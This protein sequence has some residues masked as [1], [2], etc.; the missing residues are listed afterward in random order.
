MV[1][2][3]LIGCRKD[4]A[5]YAEAAGRLRGA[6]FVATVDADPG[7]AERAATAFGTATAYPELEDLIAEDL[8]GFDAMV[9]DAPSRAHGSLVTAA[10]MLR[11]HVL[12]ESPLALSTLDA[13]EATSACQTAG[14]RLMV[15][16]AARFVPTTQV[17]K[18]SIDSGKLGQ[19]G[20]LRIHRWESRDTGDWHTLEAEA[21]IDGG[22]VMGQV[23]RE[24]DLARWM[25]G[26][27][28]TE[29]Y[30]TGR[31][32]GGAGLPDHD[33]VQ[34]HLGFPDDGM[35]LIDYS[36]ALP[37][38]Q[39][40]SSLS[41]IGSTGAAYADDHQNMNLLYRGGAPQAIDTGYGA[42]HVAAQLQ[43]FVDA[44]TEERDPAVTG[45]DGIAAV[46]VA[47]A[48]QSSIDSGHSA[49]LNGGRHELI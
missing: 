31:R 43:E 41:V 47:E 15:G 39:G 10:A 9:I 38:G 26:A 6:E 1:R 22:T 33:F 25:F 30:A 32:Q 4:G 17:V 19:P 42:Q 23:V 36:S 12:V 28:P 13:E 5:P 11:K 37:S 34:V 29:V 45:T 49:S 21:V 16:S 18:D 14:V 40:Y 24:L 44:I 2:L 48:V 7:S 20:L 8:D 27:S 3:A 46:Q 35:A